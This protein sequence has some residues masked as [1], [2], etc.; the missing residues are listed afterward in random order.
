MYQ[1]KN[2]DIN[3]RKVKQVFPEHISRKHNNNQQVTRKAYL[4]FTLTFYVKCFNLSICITVTKPSIH[5]SN[6]LK[7]LGSAYFGTRGTE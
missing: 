2:I 6:D 5:T 4:P 7:G 1:E 3:A